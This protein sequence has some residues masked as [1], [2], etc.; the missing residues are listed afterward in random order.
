MRSLVRTV[1]LLV[2]PAL[3]ALVLAAAPPL[4]AADG[5][6][7]L[8][9]QLEANQTPARSPELQELPLF[10]EDPTAAASCTAEVRCQSGA[11]IRCTSSTGPCRV[12][13]GCWVVCG[14]DVYECPPPLPN[15]PFALPCPEPLYC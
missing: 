9:A 10:L 8:E 2:L 1:H 6:A 12:F 15:D 4:E 7:G 13:T 3:A 11:R 14:C 5:S